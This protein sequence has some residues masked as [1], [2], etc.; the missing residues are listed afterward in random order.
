MKFHLI[1]N[2]KTSK[3][4][5]T[6]PR[7]LK[8]WCPV[9]HVM[10]ALANCSAHAHGCNES[11]FYWLKAGKVCDLVT[12]FTCKAQSTLLDNVLN[13]PHILSPRWKVPCL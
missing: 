3:C 8:F 5:K 11:S 2:K 7:N 13:G 12:T 6:L 9:R 4:V 1:N 10:W